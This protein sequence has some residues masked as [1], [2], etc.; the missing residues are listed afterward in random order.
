MCAHKVIGT[1]V[2]ALTVL[3]AGTAR[4]QSGKEYTPQNKR[5][6]I[7]M[8]PG[9]RT[10]QRTQILTISGR[11]VPIEQAYSMTNGGNTYIAASIGIPAVVM[12]EIP[13]EQ[14][15]DTIRDVLIKPLG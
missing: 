12:K 6:T 7:M 1:L 4:C 10:G 3:T 13:A 14:R 9:N 5:F 15:F 2:L 11:K 8:P